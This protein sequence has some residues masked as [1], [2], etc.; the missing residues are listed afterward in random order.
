M[1]TV[2]KE[3]EII[4]SREEYE[5]YNRLKKYRRNAIEQFDVIKALMFRLNVFFNL[6]IEENNS[7]EE[8]IFNLQSAMDELSE[9]CRDYEEFLK[10]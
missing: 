10:I 4:I 1:G 2:E 5:K 6:L 7:Y 3:N 8:I 9:N